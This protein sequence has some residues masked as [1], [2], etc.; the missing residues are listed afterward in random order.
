MNK[1]LGQKSVFRDVK[2]E[3][4]PIA[5]GEVENTVNLH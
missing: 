1:K 2:K 4:L 5:K 3:D